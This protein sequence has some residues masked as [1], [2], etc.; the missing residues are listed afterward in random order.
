VAAGTDSTVNSQAMPSEDSSHSPAD[1]ARERELLRY[2]QGLNG[3]VDFNTDTADSLDDLPASSPDA[4]LTALAQL[5]A[6]RLDAPRAMIRSASLI[7]NA[8]DVY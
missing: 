2:C 6:L 7:M 1:Y 8:V 4:A 5:C 3:T